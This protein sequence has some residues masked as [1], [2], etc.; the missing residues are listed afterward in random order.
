MI[1]LLGRIKRPSREG[2]ADSQALSQGA[3]R[4]HLETVGPGDAI[5]K[6]VRRDRDTVRVRAV[7]MC[8][9][10]SIRNAAFDQST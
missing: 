1:R 4:G 7:G 6:R 8:F 5:D 10:P 2:G 3:G 9:L